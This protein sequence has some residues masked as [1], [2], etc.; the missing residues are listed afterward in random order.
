MTNIIKERESS[1]ELIRVIAQYFIV[2]YHLLLVIVYK[3]TNIEFYR[4]IWIPLHI[5]VPLF[6][7]ISGYFGIKTDVRRLVKLAGMVFVL[8]VPLLIA[9]TIIGGG[10]LKDYVSIVFFVSNT[11]FWFV[12]TYLY[13]FLFAPVINYYLKNCSTRQRILLLLVLS[14][15]TI[16]IGTLKFDASLH[17]GKNLVSFIFY[18]TIGDTLRL[19]KSKWETIPRIYLASAFLI[20]NVFLVAF[21][22]IF[23][24]NRISDIVF[25]RFFYDYTSVGLL[26]NSILFFILI[27]GMNFH[28]KIVNSIGKSSLAIYMIH[29]AP[30]IIYRLLPPVIMNL[31]WL[32]DAKIPLVIMMLML[33]TGMIVITCWIIYLFLKPIWLLI[34]RLGGIVQKIFDK[35]FVFITDKVG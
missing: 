31:Y 3:N 24:N 11:P 10:S 32:V 8:Q 4:A 28:S 34:D 13:L 26:L 22:T 33:V 20:L 12:R 14:F 5:G 30:L 23:G 16:Y 15:I 21:F 9:D 1:Y 35:T 25:S 6:V 2:L 18:Y 27:G 7:M 29:G 17:D 19:Y